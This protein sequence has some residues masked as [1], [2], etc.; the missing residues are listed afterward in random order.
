M[1]PPAPGSARAAEL[2]A[3]FALPVWH[4]VAVAARADLPSPRAGIDGWVIESR[5]PAGATRPGGNAAAFDWRITHG[6]QAGLPWLLAGGLTPEVVL[7]GHGANFTELEVWSTAVRRH[8]EARAESILDAVRELGSPNTYELSCH[9]FPEITGFSHILG[10]SEVIGH[11]DL[12]GDA[13]A[14]QVSE[15]LPLRFEVA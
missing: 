4:P 13:G 8:H 15:T 1:R 5:P 11:L 9:L 3:L 10:M 7:P 2:G 12:L 14:V 6:W